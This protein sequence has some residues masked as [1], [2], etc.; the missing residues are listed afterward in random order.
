MK[1]FDEYTVQALGFALI[2][3]GIL[4]F[5][6]ALLASPYTSSLAPDAYPGCPL[7]WTGGFQVLH[8]SLE[9]A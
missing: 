2:V 3:I 4:L 1:R 6:L 5:I 7:P 8:S 9:S